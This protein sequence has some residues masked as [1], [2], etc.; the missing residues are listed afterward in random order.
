MNNGFVNVHCVEQWIQ[1]Y[2]G[3][4]GSVKVH[5]VEQWTQQYIVE[6]W[7]CLGALCQTMAPTVGE[8]WP[9]FEQWAQQYIGEQWHC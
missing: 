7:H 3:N 1:Q 5:C 9:C 6:K 2:I 4:N 8:Q